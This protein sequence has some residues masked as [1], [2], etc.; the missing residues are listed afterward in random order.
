MKITQDNFL[1]CRPLLENKIGANL[2]R[3]PIQGLG[4]TK[5]GENKH[6]T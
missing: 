2:G 5:V 6:M 3:E 1:M 4:E